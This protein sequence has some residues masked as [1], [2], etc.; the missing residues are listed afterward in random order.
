MMKDVWFTYRLNHCST[1]L[2]CTLSDPEKE[3][4]VVVSSIYSL[5]REKLKEF[6]VDVDE[7][8]DTMS[9]PK[10]EKECTILCSFMDTAPLDTE[11]E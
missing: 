1:N 3:E 7:C 5:S 9:P 2:Y 11:R 8:W 10:P 6:G 4:D